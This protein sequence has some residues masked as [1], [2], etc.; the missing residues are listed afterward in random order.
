MWYV[1]IALAAGAAASVQLGVNG[2]M[3]GALGSPLLAAMVNNSVG[4]LGI[5]ALLAVTRT[6]L[7]TATAVS[8]APWFGWF[9]GL[10]GVIYIV[11]GAILVPKL[12]VATTFVL[13]LVGQVAMALTLDVVGAFGPSHPITASR[14][15][16]AALVVVG[17]VLVFRR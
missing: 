1:L 10:L 7:P 3:R 12:G 5:V 11:S 9:A 17:A 16:G 2:L 14:F 13:I 15:L 6:S 8:S 4:L